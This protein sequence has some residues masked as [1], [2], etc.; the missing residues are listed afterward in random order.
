MLLFARITELVTAW[1]IAPARQGAPLLSVK[2]EVDCNIDLV[3]AS[4]IPVF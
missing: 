2:N 3:E 1:I 4:L